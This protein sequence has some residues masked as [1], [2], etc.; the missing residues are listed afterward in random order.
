MR[1][2]TSSATTGWVQFA[3][4]TAHC[5]LLTAA[6]PVLPGDRT[7]ACC[8]SI[9]PSLGGAQRPISGGV[10]THGAKLSSFRPRVAGN[11]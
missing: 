11:G 10:P 7:Y 3:L 4:P 6:R 2:A 8:G 1:E 9:A 5:P